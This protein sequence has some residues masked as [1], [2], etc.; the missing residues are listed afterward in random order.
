MY[1]RGIHAEEQIKPLLNFIQQNPLGIFTTAIPSAS[2]PL[3]QSSHVPWVL[4]IISD[5]AD[6]PV[7]GRL[8]GHMARQNP[9]A[10]AIIEALQSSS[11]STNTGDDITGGGD[12]VLEQEV[13]VLFNGPHHHYVTPKFYVETKPATAKVVPTWNYSAVQAY[14]KARIYH[15]SGS[16]AT[17]EYLGQQ[18]KDLTTLCETE[19]MGYTGEKGT[20]NGPWEVEDAPERYLEIMKKGVIGVE[21]EIERIGGKWKMS[22]EMSVGDRNGV[23]EGFKKLG[24]EVGIAISECVRER[25]EICD[26]AK[27]KAKERSLITRNQLPGYKT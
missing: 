12:G 3:L 14:G 11:S 2:H 4:D 17:S 7:K 16:A 6:A 23:A 13:M 24:T 25:G 8:R 19:I 1:L 18:M 9:Q 22:Q 20:T 27:R 21:I 26:E 15:S 5:D 10:K